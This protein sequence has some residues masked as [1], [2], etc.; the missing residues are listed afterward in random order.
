MLR[1]E[2]A[3]GEVYAD[4]FGTGVEAASDV[5]LALVNEVVDEGCFRVIGDFACEM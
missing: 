1:C 5:P 3:F 4:A 2:A